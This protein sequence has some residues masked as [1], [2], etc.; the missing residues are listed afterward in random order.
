MGNIRTHLIIEG[1]VQGVWF[2]DSARREAITLGVL[3]W[4]KNRPDGTVEVL[5]EGPEEQVEKFV[6]WCHQGSPLSQV[7]QI[8]ETREERKGQFKSFDIVY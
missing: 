4:V 3:G 2:R 7:R 8:H 5:V 1:R 6:T